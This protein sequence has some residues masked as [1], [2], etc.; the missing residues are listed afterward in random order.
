MAACND[1]KE[2]GLELDKELNTV[3]E[4]N[5]RITENIKEN[6]NEKNMEVL[7][8]IS[9]RKEN[10]KG[11]DL[12]SILLNVDSDLLDNSDV[13]LTLERLVNYG[14]ISSKFY[15]GKRT[16]RLSSIMCDMFHQNPKYNQQNKRDLRMRTKTTT[17]LQ[18]TAIYLSSY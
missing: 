6:I 18:I 9:E 16:Y 17:A 7:R 2:I 14:I 13:F 8:I 5:Y 10:K 15:A 3:L 1:I 4:K 11:C 12:N